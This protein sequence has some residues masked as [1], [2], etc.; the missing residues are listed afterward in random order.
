MYGIDDVQDDANNPD[1]PAEDIEC[2]S[3]ARFVLCLRKIPF[4]YNPSLRN[5][6][7]QST[8]L[9]SLNS[10]PTPPFHARGARGSQYPS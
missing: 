3:T 4:S 7:L 8:E 10:S 2:L 5:V 1:E 9:N 6:I